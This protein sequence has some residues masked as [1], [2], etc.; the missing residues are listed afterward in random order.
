MVTQRFK[1]RAASRQAVNRKAE[2]V[3]PRNRRHGKDDAVLRAEVNTGNSAN[4]Q[5]DTASPMKAGNAARG[6]EA[7]QGCGGRH[8]RNDQGK[9]RRESA[10]TDRFIPIPAN[11]TM[12]QFHLFETYRNSLNTRF[13]NKVKTLFAGVLFRGMVRT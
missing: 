9:V 10:L 4:W 12:V 1:R 3:E 7:A 11:L 5:A 2:G 8:R 6:K 13:E